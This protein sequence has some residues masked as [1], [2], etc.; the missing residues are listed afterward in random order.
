MTHHIKQQDYLGKSAD[1]RE[2]SCLQA[3]QITITGW[4][5]IF[6][7]AVCLMLS[8]NLRAD[9]NQ[10]RFY[11]LVAA[12][13]TKVSDHTNWPVPIDKNHPGIAKLAVL[14]EDKEV[15]KFFDETIDNRQIGNIIWKVD[16]I[17]SL[18]KA[19]NYRF[20][21][22]ESETVILSKDWHQPFKEKGILTFGK[23]DAANCI[24]TYSVA[25]S[26]LQFKLDLI[27]A[28]QAGVGFD[29]RLIELAIKV[30]H[31]SPNP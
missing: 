24:F 12:M 25:G 18:Q 23:N 19:A 10:Q 8:P 5:G 16:K 17:N 26:R 21:Y 11:T 9:E 4:L 30:Q 6:V 29:P 22:V 27:A 20:L 7:F 14:T 13:I 2:V 31:E 28:K 15:L 3:W 1:G